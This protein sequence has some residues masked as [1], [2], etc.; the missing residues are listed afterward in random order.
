MSSVIKKVSANLSLRLLALN[1][2]RSVSQLCRPGSYAIFRKGR[3]VVEFDVWNKFGVCF[4]WIAGGI[5]VDL[6]G[7]GESIRGDV[8]PDIRLSVNQANTGKSEF[9]VGFGA[10]RLELHGIDQEKI[11]TADEA[12]SLLLS[13]IDPE[14]KLIDLMM[15]RPDEFAHK[16]GCKGNLLSL[17]MFFGAVQAK[18]LAAMK[19][20]IN[21]YA[22]DIK[23]YNE[24][25]RIMHAM[26]AEL[27]FHEA[28]KRPC[29]FDSP[30]KAKPG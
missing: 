16:C 24:D 7:P 25:P 18:D 11:E 17:M 8:E 19:R 27:K 1:F 14:S 12:L 23:L 2:E 4:C 30:T 13:E 6:K 3:Q 20:H 28:V 26:L 9:G 5:N 22:E 15:Q 29:S 21:S 10:Q